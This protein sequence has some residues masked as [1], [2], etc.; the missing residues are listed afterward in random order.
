MVFER[1]QGSVWTYL[2]FQFLRRKKEKYAN[3]KWI[4]RIFCLR[5]NLSNDDIIFC[6]K[7]RSENGCGKCH[8]LVWNS[9]RIWGTGWHTPTKNCQE[10]PPPGKWPPPEKGALSGWIQLDPVVSGQKVNSVLK[11]LLRAVSHTQNANLKWRGTNHSN[12][13]GMSLKLENRRQ[14]TAFM[15]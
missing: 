6:L 13:A 9:I 14:E 7:A 11:S 12:F 5:S 1:T 4:W 2:S 8:F 3:S 15:P 10:Y